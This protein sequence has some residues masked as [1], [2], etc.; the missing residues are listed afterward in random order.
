MLSS[1]RR[2][3]QSIWPQVVATLLMLGVVG[4]VGF[5]VGKRAQPQIRK[6]Q[7]VTPLKLK[8]STAVPMDLRQYLPKKTIL[9]SGGIVSQ[10]QTRRH[11]S[12]RSSHD[13]SVEHAG[14]DV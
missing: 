11:V 13:A 5:A 10:W 14:D 7:P 6:S 8:P 9:R 3:R 1:R 2:P 12:A 4:T